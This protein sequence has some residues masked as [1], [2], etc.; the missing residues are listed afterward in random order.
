MRPRS[1]RRRDEREGKDPY[2]RSGPINIWAAALIG[3]GATII[4]VGAVFLFTGGD[5]PEET[6]APSDA[7]LA[8]PVTPDE[9]ALEALARR[10]IE[11][12]PS[13]QWPDLYPEFTDA[14]HQRCS[15]EEFTTVGEESAVE[16][17]PN[18]ARIRYVG[19]E[20]FDVTETTARLIIVAELIDRLQ[21]NTGADFEKVD[22]V[23]RIAPVADTT[24]CEAFDRLSG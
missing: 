2:S 24:G 1:E 18:L 23:W 3:V 15:F 17:G 14:Y 6:P 5:S 8:I 16:Q 21:Y 20:S 13:G 7:V 19:V 9:I 10:M 22:G 4:V 11:S 12:L